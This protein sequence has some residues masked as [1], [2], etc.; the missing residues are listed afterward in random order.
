M[1]ATYASLVGRRVEVVYRFC[2]LELFARGVLLDDTGTF[3]RIEQRADQYGSF[4]AFQLKIPHSFILLLKEGAGMR[5]SIASH[6]DVDGRQD[7]IA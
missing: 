6:R 3:V 4:P 2:T 7:Q 1:S 5:T